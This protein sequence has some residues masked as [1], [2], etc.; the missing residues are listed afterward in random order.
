M[1]EYKAGD[2]FEIEEPG[3]SRKVHRLSNLNQELE[4]SA[5]EQTKMPL[6]SRIV[7]LG[8]LFIGLPYYLLTRGPE[9]D[10]K[11]LTPLQQGLRIKREQDEKQ[12]RE[13]SYELDLQQKQFDAAQLEIFEQQRRE[14]EQRLKRQNSQKNPFPK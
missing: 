10:P 4:K 5:K 3:E 7:I 13:R 12:W 2:F 8:V 11:K 9:D 6:M 1:S 14:F